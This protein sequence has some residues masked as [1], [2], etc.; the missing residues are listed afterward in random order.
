MSANTVTLPTNLA[1]DRTTRFLGSAWFLFLGITVMNKLVTSADDP[2]PSLL[3]SSLVV[4]FY[5]LLA[6]LVLTRAPAKAQAEGLLPRIA[7]FVG[8]YWPWTITFFPKTEAAL[9]NLASTVCVLA[10]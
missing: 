5:L 10:G 4:V 1:Y 6:L 7:A 3:S 9:P 8:T 2:W